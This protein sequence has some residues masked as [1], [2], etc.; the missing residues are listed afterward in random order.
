MRNR[1]RSWERKKRW[2]S[3]SIDAGRSHEGCSIDLDV[4]R[5]FEPSHKEEEVPCHDLLRHLNVVLEE[6]MYVKPTGRYRS[7]GRATLSSYEM[8]RVEQ[9]PKETEVRSMVMEESD[10]R[11]QQRQLQKRVSVE[12]ESVTSSSDSVVRAAA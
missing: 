9:T 7:D 6:V 4:E 11:Q 8:W 1:P 5:Y 3:Y 12:V 2:L 10:K